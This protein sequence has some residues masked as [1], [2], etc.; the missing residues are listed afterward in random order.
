MLRDPFA[1]FPSTYD[2]AAKDRIWILQSQT[3]HR[4]WKGKIV[5]DSP[6][7]LSEDDI[8]TIIRILDLHGKG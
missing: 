8:D 5:N 6:H 2:T 3:F 1:E 7:S 4:F